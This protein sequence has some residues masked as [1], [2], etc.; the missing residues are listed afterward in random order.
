MLSAPVI[1]L[2]ALPHSVNIIIADTTGR[3][4]P[5]KV[6]MVAH[7]ILAPHIV[8]NITELVAAVM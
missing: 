8:P 2:R 3:I 6:G 7:K 5:E 4:T 1:E